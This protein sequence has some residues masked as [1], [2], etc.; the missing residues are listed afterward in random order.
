MQV[1]TQWQNNRGQPVCMDTENCT[2]DTEGRDQVWPFY[3]GVWWACSFHGNQVICL[4]NQDVQL[5]PVLSHWFFAWVEARQW[6]RNGPEPTWRFFSVSPFVFS[7]VVFLGVTYFKEITSS[8]LY[9]L[10]VDVEE[11]EA[12]QKKKKKSIICRKYKIVAFCVDI[13]CNCKLFL[14][15]L[16]CFLSKDTCDIVYLGQ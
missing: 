12:C 2:K 7:A 10:K 16:R 11:T 4:L 13:T 6:V 15:V 14:K 8:P 5:S 9:W 3:E 1:A